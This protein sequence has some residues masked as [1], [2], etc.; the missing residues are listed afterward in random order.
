MFHIFE[1]FFLTPDD[2][3]AA[4]AGREQQILDR[5][6]KLVEI[7]SPSWDKEASTRIT[8]VLIGWFSALDVQIE[9]V[10]TEAGTHLVIEAPGT[11]DEAPLLLIGH[12]D[13]V[14]PRGTL[15]TS[16]PWSVKNDVVR[17]PGAFDMKSGLVMMLTALEILKGKPRRSVRILVNADEEVG[18]PTSQD[19]A[20]RAT[21]GVGGA[22]GFESPHPDGAFK[23]GRR[24]TTRVRVDVKGLASHAAL[25]PDKGISAIEELVDQLLVLRSVVDEASATVQVLCNIG[26]ISGGTRANVVPDQ[27][28]AEIGLRFIDGDSERVV[29]ERLGHLT[30]VRQGAVVTT[31]VLSTRPA[32]KADDGDEALLEKVA[33]VAQGFGWEAHGRPA[34]G[35]GDTNL[36]GALGVPTIDGFGPCGGGAHA[37]DEHFMLPDLYRRT[38]L[39]VGFLQR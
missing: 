17:G 5:V 10:H 8:D 19:L 28:S 21:A 29:L 33:A 1:G 22:I 12:S 23:V 32:W 4:V 25:D 11:T 14:W 3:R 18:S 37:V 36:V 35:A 30:P 6:K 9:P 27:A 24:G 16:L 39:L 31:T 26:T 13:T 34:A 15:D 38:T 7:E 20:Q 2:M